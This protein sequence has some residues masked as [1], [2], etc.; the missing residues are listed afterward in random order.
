MLR[1]AHG[2]HT[3]AST[4]RFP[5]TVARLYFPRN[6]R[7][8]NVYT[9]AC[10]RR[11]R[12]YLDHFIFASAPAFHSVSTRSFGDYCL[13]LSPSHK[14]LTTFFE[15]RRLLIWIITMAGDCERAKNV[16]KSLFTNKSVFAHTRRGLC[17]CAETRFPSSNAFAHGADSSA[18]TA[19][20]TSEH[21]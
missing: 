15:E 21:T 11:V 2:C 7:L 13:D 16:Q 17:A 20:V 10:R 12:R 6:G 4:K 3:G 14:Y 19:S 18:T 5:A 1:R 8:Q 9:R